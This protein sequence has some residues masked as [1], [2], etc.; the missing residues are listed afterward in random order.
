MIPLSDDPRSRRL[1]WVTILLIVANIA[2]FVYELGLSERRL[3]VFVAAFGTVP[4]EI[5][6]GRDLPPASPTPVYLTLLTAMFIHGGFLH[7]GSN[8]LYLWVFGDNVEDKFGHVT[9][10]FFYFASGIIASLSH[11]LVNA[12]SDIPSVGASGA[13]AGVLGAYLLLFPGAQ[14]R[15]LLFLGPILLFPR[16][17]AFILIGFWFLS[18]FF[19][20][21]ASLGMRSEQTSGVA[22]WA[23]IGGFVAGFLLALVLRPREPARPTAPW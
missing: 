8:L 21:L 4:L 6:T 1:P 14:V 17:S 19:S 13:I 16:I 2:V 15:T 9:Y 18:Q 5:M 23:H 3:D 7:I 22:V 11:V 12:G 20:G 10:L